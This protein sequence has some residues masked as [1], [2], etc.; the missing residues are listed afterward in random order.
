MHWSEY[1]RFGISLFVLLAPFLQV[2]LLLSLAGGADRAVIMRTATVATITALAI[3]LGAHY[4][5]ELFLTALGASLASFQIGG[6]LI[7]LL[8][9]LSLIQGDS[10]ASNVKQGLHDSSP[11][12]TLPFR[13]GVTPMGTPMLAGAG[14][15]TAV[16]LETHEEH[17]LRDE[18]A[19]ILIILLNALA[20]WVVLACAPTIGR[21]L[22]RN[23]I[24]VLQRIVGLVVVAVGVEILVSGIGTHFSK[25]A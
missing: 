17:G 16:I 4:A 24:L 1:T 6:G 18:V 11:S 25:L 2:P 3:L 8:I 20:V 19:I 21:L 12:S 22:G 23:G 5:G 7:V 13:I 10:L 15:I 9:G 14:A